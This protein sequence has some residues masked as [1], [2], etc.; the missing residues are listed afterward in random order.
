[1]RRIELILIFNRKISVPSSKQIHV[2]IRGIIPA[3]LTGSITTSVSKLHEGKKEGQV[4]L[5]S[6]RPRG[7]D[8]V[9]S[10]CTT[11]DFAFGELV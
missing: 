2:N 10:K 3:V 4:G 7:L 6:L 1:M 5:L 11:N 9:L 8:R